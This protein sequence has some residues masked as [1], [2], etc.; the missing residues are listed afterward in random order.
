MADEKRMSN[1]T[2]LV[3]A[4]MCSKNV[5]ELEAVSDIN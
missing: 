1:N 3:V 2:V 4:Q 5:F